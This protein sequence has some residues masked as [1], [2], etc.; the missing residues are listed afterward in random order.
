MA[1]ERAKRNLILQRIG[2]L[3]LIILSA[4]GAWY[5]V[6]Y[7]TARSR[8]AQVLARILEIQNIL[9]SYAVRH[10]VYPSMGQES[11][12]LGDPD[13]S[14]LSTDG[15][16]RANSDSCRERSFGFFG[17]L[18]GTGGSQIATYT[19]LA[20]DTVS[21]CTDKNGCPSYKIEFIFETH[22]IASQGAH[23]VGPD[24]LIPPP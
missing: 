8:D 23:F 12:I 5:L 22:S 3:L 7:E 17:H 18:P 19:S 11:R 20:S 24:G 10:G 16:V 1:I 4:T 21:A 9:T 13:T 15:F 2:A 14:C 6:R